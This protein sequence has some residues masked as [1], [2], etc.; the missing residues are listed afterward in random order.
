MS[1]DADM[2]DLAAWIQQTN[3]APEQPPVGGDGEGDL[4]AELE[5]MDPAQR[6]A[7]IP[8]GEPD[9]LDEEGLTDDA[10]TLAM[11]GEGHTACALSLSLG[12]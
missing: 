2:A 9:L 5:D 12:V 4:A 6:A 11:V 3:L 8:E 10:R 1:S 7:W